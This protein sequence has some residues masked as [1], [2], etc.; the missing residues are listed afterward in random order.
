MD[1]V[2]LGTDALAKAGMVAVGLFDPPTKVGGNLY[3]EFRWDID[4]HEQRCGPTPLKDKP[5]FHE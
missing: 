1:P 2:G 5:G 4:I 3:P